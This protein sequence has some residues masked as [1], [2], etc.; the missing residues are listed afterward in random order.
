MAVY[1]VVEYNNVK[2]LDDNCN[3]TWY[4]GEAN[5][6]DSFINITEDMTSREVC[7][8]LKEGGFLPSADMRKFSVSDLDKDI[9]EITTKQKKKPLCRL[10][11]MV[12][13]GIVRI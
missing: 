6:T 7:Q 11:K 3:G 8:S 2:R 13:P 1:L 4:I 9:I 10:E 5:K 12:P